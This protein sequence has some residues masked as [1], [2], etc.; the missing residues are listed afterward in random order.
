MALPLVTSDTGHGPTRRSSAGLYV[1]TTLLLAATV[2]AQQPVDMAQKV[3]FSHYG[4]PLPQ[5]LDALQQEAGIKFEVRG[6]ARREIVVVAVTDVTLADLVAKVGDVTATKFTD[7]GGKLVVEQDTAALKKLTDQIFQVR[8]KMVKEAKQRLLNDLKAPSPEA[9]EDPSNAMMSDVL[10]QLSDSFLA[11]L[12]P[13]ERVVFSSSPTA[14]QRAFRPNYAALNKWVEGNNKAWQDYADE[15]KADGATQEV[16]ND[17]LSHISVARTSKVLVV[18]S[19]DGTDWTHS[20]PSVEVVLYDQKGE[21]LGQAVVQLDESDGEKENQPP[22]KGDGESIEYSQLSAEAASHFHA[23]D[24]EVTPLPDALVKL[25]TQPELRDPVSI[26]LGEALLQTAKKTNKDIVA[27]FDDSECAADRERYTTVG[28]LRKYLADELDETVPG[29]WIVRLFDPLGARAQRVDRTLL[30]G[31]LTEVAKTG[32]P[33]LETYSQFAIKVPLADDNSLISS[34]LRLVAPGLDGAGMSIGDTSLY[35]YLS[36]GQRNQLAG[37]GKLEYRSFGPGLKQ[38][39]SRKVF[40]NDGLDKFGLERPTQG[41]NERYDEERGTFALWQ[42]PTEVLPRGLLPQSELYGFK[43]EEP[44][45][46]SYGLGGRA[47][48][49]S[50]PLTAYDI[51]EALSY[52]GQEDSAYLQFLARMERSSVG[53][54]E[55]WDFRFFVA[56]GI[57]QEYSMR[58]FN[59]P[60]KSKTYSWKNLPPAFQQAVNKALDNIRNGGDPPEGRF[61]K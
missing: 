32:L 29:W 55:T 46:I 3:T 43:A 58:G 9:E 27:N 18:V 42:E 52:E 47:D 39:L 16:I 61:K 49:Y 7:D 11:G 12:G 26:V 35:G 53:T 17:A 41:F 33:N 25:L 14:M 15:L 20:A 40:S 21:A 57:G 48:G 44:Y 22:V 13:D 23:S 34:T 56:P 45:A 59:A 36:A 54:S 38:Y 31:L 28:E 10:I 19:R 2:L 4:G 5:V 60:D 30:G 50:V 51:A 24:T 8:L 37:G 1:M 6:E